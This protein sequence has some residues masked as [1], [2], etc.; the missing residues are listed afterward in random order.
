MGNNSR[1]IYNSS[2]FYELFRKK[3][4]VMRNTV[5]VKKHMGKY[6]LLY[7]DLSD[8]EGTSEEIRERLG[9]K[10]QGLLTENSHLLNF[11]EKELKNTQSEGTKFEMTMKKA[12][13][14]K[15]RAE[16]RRVDWTH[17]FIFL[18]LNFFLVLSRKSK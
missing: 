4:S 12:E 6:P 11:I 14:K 15:Y 18:F 8:I 17:G 5:F 1:H 16:L 3:F 9:K 10:I 13:F 2:A 7:V